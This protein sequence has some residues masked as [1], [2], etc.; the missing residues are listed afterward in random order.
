[1]AQYDL[2]LF[3]IGAGSGGVR[4]ARVASQHGARVAI[5]EEANFGGTCVNRGCVP[6]KLFVYASRFAA[7]FEQA[8]AYGWQLPKPAFDWP[9]LLRNKDAEIAR[10]ESVYRRNLDQAGV[11]IHAE[12]AVLEDAHTVRLSTS[13]KRLTAAHILIAVGGRPHAGPAFPGQELAITSDE[14]FHLQ[15]LPRRILIVGGGY[16]AIEFAGIFAGLGVNTALLHRGPHV[17]RGFDEEIRTTL[18]DSYRQ[19]GI[20]MLMNNTLARL[21]KTADGLRATLA[22]GSTVETDVVMLCVGRRPYT[23]ELGLDAAG[24][25]TGKN[26]EIRVDA[27]S[28]TNVPSIHAVGDVTDR[29]NLTPVAIREGQAFADSVFGQRPA[30]VDH[31]LVPTAVFSTPEIGTVGPSEEAARER[32]PA[33]KVYRARFRPMK[34]AFAASNEPMLMKLLVDGETDRVV[35]AHVLGE[36]GAEMIQL[37]AVSIGM[38]AT[39]A[40]LDRTIALHPSAAEE[41]VTMR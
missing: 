23:G 6:K 9:T 39:K 37:L 16:I 12:R 33:L 28:C 8:A 27:Q 22:D 25:A 4:A 24:V 30:T 31:S 18:E 10:L 13:G 17:L 36:G 35:G 20:R 2:D 5:A 21:E 19:R 11:T 29:V 32:Y 14:V 7:E 34:T 15:Q 3:V 41:W 40:D 38:G 26:G 1:M